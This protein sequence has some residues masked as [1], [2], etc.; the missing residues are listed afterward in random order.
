MVYQN[1]F[2]CET[3]V[4]YFPPPKNSTDSS[5]SPPKPRRSRSVSA[6][7]VR[8][9]VTNSSQRPSDLSGQTK[10][11][12]QYFSFVQEETN[13]EL[14]KDGVKQTMGLDPKNQ[15][16]AV[17]IGGGSVADLKTPTRSSVV[18]DRTG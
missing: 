14:Q 10:R 12:A 8:D 1:I 15:L 3:K 7:L 16:G 9:L 5:L 17:W 4:S 18:T 13:V 2:T 11:A 6:V